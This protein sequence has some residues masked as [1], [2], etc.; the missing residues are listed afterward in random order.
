VDERRGVGCMLRTGQS[1]LAAAV[2]WARVVKREVGL[3]L[4]LP[5]LGVGLFSGAGFFRW[6]KLF[7]ASACR[8][9]LL[10]FFFFGVVDGDFVRRTAS[11][12]ATR[13]TWAG[14]SFYPFLLAFFRASA[15]TRGGD[16]QLVRELDIDDGPV[17]LASWDASLCLSIP[18][19]FLS[20]LVLENWGIECD[21][22]AR[23][24]FGR[25]LWVSQ[26]PRRMSRP[27]EVDWFP[28]R[29]VSRRRILDALFTS[30]V[31]VYP[32]S[33]VLLLDADTRRRYDSSCRGPP[34]LSILLLVPALAIVSDARS[35]RIAW[36]WDCSPAHELR[37]RLSL[38]MSV[39]N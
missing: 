32:P 11:S 4:F 13:L 38:A 14:L 16:V 34:A 15:S 17:V 18:L 8:S 29:D 26:C 35:R 30:C 5:F 24:V 25:Y 36:R 2:G 6:H 28:G 27:S 7:V 22:R 39:N 3:C 23:I 10:S 9:D 20:S 12:R 33:L 1:L 19:F 37:V 21:Q 31:P